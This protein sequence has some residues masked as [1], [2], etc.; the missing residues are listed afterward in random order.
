MGKM[1]IGSSSFLPI[2]RSAIK[3]RMSSNFG[4][5]RLRTAELAALESK[6]LCMPLF[7]ARMKKYTIKNEGLTR[8][9]HNISP[10]VSLW[11]FFQTLKEKLTPESMVG[12]GRISN[13]SAT[14]WLSM[15]P[16][17]M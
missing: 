4:Q 7:P 2:T 12:S 10:I 13:S 3:S 9:G 8:S 15:L 11:G 17:K 6:L 5:I 14:L 1:S 16:T